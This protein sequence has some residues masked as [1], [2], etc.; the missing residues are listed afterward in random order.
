[1]D[2]IIREFEVAATVERAFS[3]WTAKAST[4]WPREHTL[5]GEDHVEVVFEP[6]VGGRIYE[7]TSAGEELEW[8]QVMTWDPPRRVSYLWHLF[9]DRSEAT[10]VVVSFVPTPDGRTRVTIQQSGFERLGADAARRRE[11]TDVAWQHLGD[12]YRRAL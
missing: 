8:G 7:R 11:R 2:A 3:V 10:E 6:E 1:M 5:A 4:W 12:L 9:C